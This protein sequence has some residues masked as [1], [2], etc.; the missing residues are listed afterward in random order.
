[1]VTVTKDNRKR[2][3]SDMEWLHLQADPNGWELEVAPPELPE[4]VKQMVARKNKKHGS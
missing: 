1:M 4:E 2:T 3:I